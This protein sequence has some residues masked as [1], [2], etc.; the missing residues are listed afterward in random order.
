MEDELKLQSEK[1]IEQDKNWWQDIA[2]E[3][4]IVA[5]ETFLCGS[6]APWEPKWEYASMIDYRCAEHEMV[7]HRTIRALEPSDLRDGLKSIN[8]ESCNG[9]SYAW[10]THPHT[11]VPLGYEVSRAWSD[12]GDEGAPDDG[13]VPFKGFKKPRHERHHQ[14]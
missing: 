2:E 5:V 6:D 11:G 7:H 12:P 14:L 13:W 4:Q 9:E 8:P 1:I 3:W 10:Y